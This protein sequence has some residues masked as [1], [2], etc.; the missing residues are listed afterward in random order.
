[1]KL[2]LAYSPCP[3]DTFIFHAMINGLIDTEGLSFEVELHDVEALNLKA[4]EQTFD[5]TK[6]SYHAF[7]HLQDKYKLLESGSALGEGIGPLL[8]SKHA[9]SLEDLNKA[10]IAIPGKYTTAAF[11]FQLSYPSAKNLKV[12]VF[13]EIEEAIKQGEVDAGVII[14]ENRFTY[15]ERGFQLIS[16]LG[17]WWE[18][19]TKM[20]IPLGGIT[21][22]RNINQS[23][24]EKVARIMHRSVLY[25]QQNPEASKAYVAEH[26]QEM[27][28]SIQKK[29]IKTYVNDYTLNLGERGKASVHHLLDFSHKKG[30][31]LKPKEDLFV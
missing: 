24:Q 11:L 18:K 15:A 13:D 2:T 22:S 25:A 30:L 3:N 19:T 31:T 29:H 6:L 27:H 26:A 7:A 9:L 12:M 16:D 17:E 5:I 21:I 28:T 23:I 4:F 8:I 10:K 1:M 20:S 14:H